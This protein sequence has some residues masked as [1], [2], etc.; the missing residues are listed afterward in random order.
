MSMKHLLSAGVGSLLLSSAAIAALPMV[1]GSIKSLDTTKHE[2]VLDTGKT[3]EAPKV[4]LSAF[5]IGQKVMIS[6]ELKDGKMI[7]DKVEAAK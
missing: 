2:I 4:D 5:K 3:F 6:Y 7:A 1:T